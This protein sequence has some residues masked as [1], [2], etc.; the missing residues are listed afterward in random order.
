[1]TENDAQAPVKYLPRLTVKAAT[2]DDLKEAAK[3]GMHDLKARPALSFFFGL[4]YALIGGA[5]ILGFTVL[6]QFWIVIA[7]GMGFP[8]VAPFLAAGLYE[9]SRR[10]ERGE[11]FVAKD[12]FLVVF[13]QRRREFSWMAFVMLFVF[14]IWAYQARILLAIFLQNHSILSLDNLATA[15][16]TTNEGLAFLVTGSVVGAVIST[17]LFSITVISMPL[18]LEKEIDFITAMI[19]SVKTVLES[20][21]V[22]L[23]WGALVGALTLLSVAPAMIGVIFIFPVL[24][25][26]SW[27]LYRRLVSEVSAEA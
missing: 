5:V 12:I 23:T 22:M 8:L 9:T 1:M 4:V 7:A 19:T 11:P 26:I 24:G 14:W 20:P 6:D 18:L 3:A 15:V 13:N 21:L 10:L 27:H 2:W 25:H 16:F 17:F